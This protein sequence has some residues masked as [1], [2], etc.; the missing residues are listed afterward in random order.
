[1]S[2][3]LALDIAQSLTA[4][5]IL[6]RDLE[7]EALSRY[8]DK[9][10]P[11]GEALVMIAPVANMEAYNYRQLSELFGR[12][13]AKDGYEDPDID[14]A[15]P[16]LVLAD[17]HE[18]IRKARGLPAATKRAT[19]LRE[20]D[21][22]RASIDWML[23]ENEDGIPNFMPADELAQALADLEK[24]LERILKAGDQVDRGAPCMTCGGLLIMEYAEAKGPRE[25]DRWHCPKCHQ[26]STRDQYSM[27]VKNDY[28]QNSP[29]LTAED[30][31][32]RLGIAA[33]Q[34]RVWG[35]RDDTLKAG[36]NA[37]GLLTYN[38]AGLEAKLMQQ[39]SVQTVA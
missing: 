6:V 8:A 20:A 16:L 21:G 33:T 39:D 1:M 5:T 24:R 29:T 26:W 17:W 19:I 9:D 22:I 34:I 13:N 25:D 36:K 37:N 18:Q 23:A 32:I 14:A 7:G 15:P 11:G 28:L 31:A 27:A 3:D 10:M 35:S 38:V 4:I 2:T 12:T 30:A